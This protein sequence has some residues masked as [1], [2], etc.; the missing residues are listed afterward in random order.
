M[1]EIYSTFKLVTERFDPAK[2][3]PLSHSNAAAFSCFT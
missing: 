1:S 2:N 3:L